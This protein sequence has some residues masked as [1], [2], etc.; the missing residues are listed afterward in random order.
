MY[1]MSGGLLCSCAFVGAIVSAI[2]LNRHASLGA[3]IEFLVLNNYLL[4]GL[5][6]WDEFWE[7]ILLGSGVGLWGA[8]SSFLGLLGSGFKGFHVK[9]WN[10]V[11]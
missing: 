8:A 6:P 2:A 3:H 4:S 7:V 11:A 9:L 1:L 10:S 5:D